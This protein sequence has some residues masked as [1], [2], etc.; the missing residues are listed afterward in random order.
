MTATAWI[1]A[2]IAARVARRASYP[3]PQACHGARF[4]RARQPGVVYLLTRAVNTPGGWRV[5]SFEGEVPTGHVFFAQ[6]DDALHE[7]SLDWCDYIGGA[8]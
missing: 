6:L 8:S 3:A 1:D 2:R 4:T 5:T 7:L